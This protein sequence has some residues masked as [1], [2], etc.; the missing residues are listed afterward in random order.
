MNGFEGSGRSL[1]IIPM[2]TRLFAAKLA[3]SAASWRNTTNPLVRTTQSLSAIGPAAMYLPFD[4]SA[5]YE[6][7]ALRQIEH[8]VSVSLRN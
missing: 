8:W 7:T 5:V 4:T 2:L 3:G 6:T 1:H